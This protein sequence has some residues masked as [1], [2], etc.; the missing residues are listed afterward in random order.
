MN[1]H[2]HGLHPLYAYAIVFRF[3]VFLVLL[4]ILSHAIASNGM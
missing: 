3:V 4:F 2:E 1:C